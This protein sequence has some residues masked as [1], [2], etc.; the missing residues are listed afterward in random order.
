MTLRIAAALVL[1]AALAGCAGDPPEPPQHHEE[2]WAPPSA[3]LLRYADKDGLLTRAGLEAGLR[4]DFD[5]A[6]TNHDGVLEPDEMRKVNEQRWEE[7]KSAVSP[8]V[9]WNGDGVI[10]FNEFAATARN[11]FPQYDFNHNGVLDPGELRPA[12]APRAQGT[13]QDQ[14]GESG[15]KQG[16]RGGRHGGPQGGGPAG[17]NGSPGGG[18]DKQ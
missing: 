5:A 13:S 18:E 8:L 14:P 17:G 12:G 4:K 1:T 16:G 7:D 3:I 10:D 6:D 9:D 2:G 15:G 11:L